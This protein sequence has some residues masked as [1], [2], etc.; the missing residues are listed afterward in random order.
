MDSIQ[1]NNTTK[2]RI[3]QTAK[4]LF[5]EQGFKN[6]TI[7]QIAAEAKVP[8]GSVT[9]YYKKEDFMYQIFVDF[10]DLIKQRIIETIDAEIENKLQR[11]IIAG[12]IYFNIIFDHE[13]SKAFYR[14]LILDDIFQEEKHRRIKKL[15]LDV[16]KDWDLNIHD[17]TMLDNILEAEIGA[18][19]HLLKIRYDILEPRISAAFIDFTLTITFRLL[20]VPAE[21]VDQNIQKAEELL[22]KIDYSDLELF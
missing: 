8:K 16:I 19:H 7:A 3:F 6:T 5:K 2:E 14:E 15:Y 13:K 1:G 11:H 22:K 18:R 10:L 9:Y 20:G 21:V 12:R 4:Q 17:Q